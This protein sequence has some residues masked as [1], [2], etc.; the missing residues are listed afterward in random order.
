VMG[1]DAVVKNVTGYAPKHRFLGNQSSTYVD[2][3]LRYSD[4]E[5][6]ASGEMVNDTL[7]FGSIQVPSVTFGVADKVA[8]WYAYDQAEGVFGFNP[9]PSNSS[10]AINQILAGLDDPI[11]SVYL[12]RNWNYTINGTGTLTL[13]GD[14]TTNCDPSYTYAPAVNE[15]LWEFTASSLSYGGKTLNVSR[16]VALYK[17]TNFVYAT[18]NFTDFVAGVFGANYNTSSSY[19]ELGCDQATN[20]QQLQKVIKMNLVGGSKA[21][22]LTINDFIMKNPYNTNSNACILGLWPGVDENSTYYMYVGTLFMR[23]HCLSMNLATQ[24]IGIGNLKKQ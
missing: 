1:P 23:N 22:K 15:T 21:A 20:A 3:G 8:G 11:I 19:Y 7:A 10:V 16:K 6:W 17:W 12:N 24:E 2:T 5:Q 4:G 13:G 14:D 9:H 18:Q